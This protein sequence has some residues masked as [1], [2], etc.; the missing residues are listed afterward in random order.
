MK[1]TKE[2]YEYLLSLIENYSLYTYKE[3]V[4]KYNELTGSNETEE[5]I[6]GIMNYFG[7]SMRKHRINKVLELRK[8]GL[9]N[10]QIANIV[11]LNREAVSRIGC[12]FGSKKIKRRKP[13]F[14]KETKF[15]RKLIEE[16][17]KNNYNLNKTGR[18]I[19]IRF[20]ELV[21]I[22]KY[23]DLYDLWKSKAQSRDGSKTRKCI[24]YYRQ[25]PDASP[26]KICKLVGCDYKVAWRAKKRFEKEALA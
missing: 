22:L 24:E 20:S 3:L 17:E 11:G 21:K 4:L 2:N 26:H 7:F 14:W 9:T 25:Y 6:R 19:G 18:K 8:I 1:Y 12:T 10:Q 15:R 13:G 23:H 5:T 16:L